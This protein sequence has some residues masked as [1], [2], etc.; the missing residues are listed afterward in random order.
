MAIPVA[1][2]EIVQVLHQYDLEGQK[3]EN[4]WYFRAEAADPDMLAHLLADIATCLLALV[5]YLS[6]TYTLERLKAKI[7]APAVSFEEEWL[8]AVGDAIAG[9]S[10]G[11]SE[12]S[13]TS[14]LISLYTTR[15]GREGRGRIYMGGVAEGDTTASILNPEAPLW[16]ALI[17]FCAC[18]LDKFKTRDPFVAGN[19]TW[20]VMSRKLGGVKPPFAIGGYAQ[21]I[22]AVP[23]RELA[24]TR[25]RKLGHGR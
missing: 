24:T 17:A 6:A 8:P 25:S 23:K 13:F 5:P 9:A 18:M 19:Y 2:G 4:V 1:A 16:G 21:I 15:P 7:V 11:D 22:R 3:C 10:A 12:P 20:G 14:A